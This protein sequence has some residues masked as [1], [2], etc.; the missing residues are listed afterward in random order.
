MLCVFR[1]TVGLDQI[2]G[3]GG[4]I[5]ARIR[6]G[7][8]SA[9]SYETPPLVGSTDVRQSGEITCDPAQQHLFLQVDPLISGRPAGAD[10]L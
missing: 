8:A 4:C 10:P 5:Q 7:E 9:P 3:P 1:T 2:S 6:L